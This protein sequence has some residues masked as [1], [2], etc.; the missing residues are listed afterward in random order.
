MLDSSATISN[1]RR[2]VGLVVCYTKTIP[3]LYLR[4]DVNIVWQEIES[5]REQAKVPGPE[6]TI[7][8]RIHLTPRDATCFRRGWVTSPPSLCR[9]HI[10]AASRKESLGREESMSPDFPEPVGTPEADRDRPGSA[11]PTIC[12]NKGA[13]PKTKPKGSPAPA[14]AGPS[15]PA[16][17]TLIHGA[18]KYSGSQQAPAQPRSSS[19]PFS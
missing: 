3:F 9:S 15:G 11:A 1:R 8:A 17:T 7:F 12:A 14:T 13:I 10:G 16:A 6:E 2:R 4:C 5:S 18:K 19:L